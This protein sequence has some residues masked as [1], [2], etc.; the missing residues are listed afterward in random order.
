MSNRPDVIIV[1]DDQGVRRSLQLLL[2]GH[3]YRVKAYADPTSV[4]SDP[5]A[6][7]DEREHRDR[8]DGEVPV[9]GIKKHVHHTAMDHAEAGQPDLLGGVLDAVGGLVVVAVVRVAGGGH[10][11]GFLERGRVAGL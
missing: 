10:A 9:R 4:A 1:D 7:A 5:E 6:D 11:K 3:G 2:R 8:G